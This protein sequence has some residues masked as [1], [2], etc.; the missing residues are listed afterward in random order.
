MCVS[1]PPATSGHSRQARDRRRSARRR[2]DPVATPLP[3][4]HSRSRPAYV[5]YVRCGRLV[6]ITLSAIPGTRSRI[7]G[8]PTGP[9]FVSPGSSEAKPR[10]IGSSKRTSRPPSPWPLV[11]PP[12]GAGGTNDDARR[13]RKSGLE[14]A[15]NNTREDSY[16]VLVCNDSALGDFANPAF[17]VPRSARIRHIR[18]A[19]GVRRGVERG[20][21]HLR[22]GRSLHD[23]TSALGDTVDHFIWS[24]PIVAAIC[25][26]TRCIVPLRGTAI[27]RQ[28]VP[29]R[30]IPMS[31][32][33]SVPAS[34]TASRRV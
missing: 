8:V 15:Y 33:P 13:S 6:Q 19:D 29:S 27:V 21:L 24:R 32:H 17:E 28:Q 31:Q 4:G 3:A 22:V 12:W 5:A 2:R 18:Q 11:V 34:D 30:A 9:H 10:S 26:L 25:F 23:T 14:N 20:R 1:F 7:P 16:R